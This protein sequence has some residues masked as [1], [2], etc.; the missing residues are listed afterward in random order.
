MK[1]TNEFLLGKLNG[2]TKEQKK[3]NVEIQPTNTAVELDLS[4]NNVAQKAIF[5]LR[6][7]YST[8]LTTIAIISAQFIEH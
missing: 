4:L 6:T 5:G 2:E 7:E 3:Q 8:Q 1:T